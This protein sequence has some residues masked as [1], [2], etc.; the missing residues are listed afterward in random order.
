MT[1]LFPHCGTVSRGGGGKLGFNDGLL[2][3]TPLMVT[4]DRIRSP[5]ERVGELR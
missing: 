4:G 3:G 2:N 1:A 5:F